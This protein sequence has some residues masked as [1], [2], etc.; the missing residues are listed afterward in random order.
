M[1]K[2]KQGV[3]IRPS[4][5]FTAMP[6]PLNL[7][8]RDAVKRIQ[9]MSFT[10]FQ[11][12]YVC[13]V[14]TENDYLDIRHVPVIWEKV[15]EPH[16]KSHLF[17]MAYC[18]A[19]LDT[20]LVALAWTIDKA[21]DACDQ[22]GNEAGLLWLSS[23]PSYR[24]TLAVKSQHN[25]RRFASW[26]HQVRDWMVSLARSRGLTARQVLIEYSIKVL[27]D[28]PL[29]SLKGWRKTLENEWSEWSSYLTTENRTI[30]RFFSLIHG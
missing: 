28:D 17:F 12:E 7:G 1:A 24:S 11:S 13:P 18:L 16:S 21:G 4:S 10:E 27:L 8:D 23:R 30:S 2:D 20:N 25:R 9:S 5:D 26:N 14:L 22:D 29:V 15:V 6:Q 19:K 3:G